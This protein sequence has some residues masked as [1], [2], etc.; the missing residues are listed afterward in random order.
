MGRAWVFAM[1]LSVFSVSCCCFRGTA[2]NPTVGLS[3]D[4]LLICSDIIF[5]G[6]SKY[7]LTHIGFF[8]SCLHSR[9]HDTW[10][11]TI[12]KGRADDTVFHPPCSDML[13]LEL[14]QATTCLSSPSHL[15]PQPHP[16]ISLPPWTDCLLCALLHLPDGSM[17]WALPS[18]PT[19]PCYY[20]LFAVLPASHKVWQHLCLHETQSSFVLI[21]MLRS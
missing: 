8:F 15:T 2:S 3:L 4:P 20:I 7:F 14:L 19:S 17:P 18:C 16:C 12:N 21:P 10:K 9:G 5:L 13:P 11:P 1:L 6:I